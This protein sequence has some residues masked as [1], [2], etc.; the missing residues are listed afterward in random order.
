MSYEDWSVGDAFGVKET[1]LVSVENGTSLEQRLIDGSVIGT[2]LS[3]LIHINYMH[4]MIK[5][6]Q[7]TIMLRH[8]QF[9]K[10]IKI[11]PS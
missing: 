8:D 6:I 11:P 7:G 1:M 2:I 9:D 10:L 3:V 4:V 5:G